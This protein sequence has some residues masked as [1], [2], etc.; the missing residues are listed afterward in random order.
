ML[1]DRGLGAGGRLAD[2]DDRDLDVDL[3]ARLDG[4]EVGVEEVAG[5]GVA[6]NVLDE[7]ELALPVEL[8][9][10][11]RV[12]VAADDE[13]EVVPGDVHVDRLAAVSVDDGGNEAGSA[14][15]AGSAL[16]ELGTGLRVKN[17]GVAHE[18]PPVVL[19]LPLRRDEP[20]GGGFPFG[21][22]DHGGYR[23]ALAGATP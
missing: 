17:R 19:V 16:A 12:L 4:E 11:E 2:D 20:R 18:M 3:L 7:D 8:E 23:S 1:F 21:P 5:H 15:A 10:D 13:E 6:L 9:L 14:G 22:V